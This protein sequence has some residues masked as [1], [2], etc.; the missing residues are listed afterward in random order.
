MN[1]AITW[2]SGAALRQRLSRDMPA[3]EPAKAVAARARAAVA[4][5]RENAQLVARAPKPAKASTAAPRRA[6]DHTN[7][8]AHRLNAYAAKFWKGQTK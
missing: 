5:A 8:T 7:T 2:M 6:V 4:L 1:H 3:L